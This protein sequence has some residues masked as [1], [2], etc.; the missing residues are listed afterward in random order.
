MGR[1]IPVCTEEIHLA[2]LVVSGVSGRVSRI[3][4]KVTRVGSAHTKPL[5]PPSCRCSTSTWED[6]PSQP[7]K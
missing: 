6:R 7:L 4:E 1:L 3:V 2:T 5:L